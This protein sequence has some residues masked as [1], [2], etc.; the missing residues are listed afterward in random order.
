M[1][2][3]KSLKVD[4][5]RRSYAR[6]TNPETGESVTYD[7][8][9]RPDFSYL[10]WKENRPENFLYGMWFEKKVGI[11]RLT[12][13]DYTFRFESVGSHP[14]ARAEDSGRPGQNCRLDGISLRKFPWEDLYGQ[15]QRYLAEEKKRFAAMVVQ[16][17]KAVANL[18]AAIERFHRDTNEYPRSLDELIDCPERLSTRAGKW[19]YVTEIPADPWEQGYRYTCPGNFNPSGFDVYSVHGNSREPSVWIG[20]WPSPYRIRDA[21]EGEDL[22]VSTKS[23]NVTVSKQAIGVASF[24]PLSLVL[25]PA[26]IL[27]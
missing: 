21:L 14:L 6:V 17:E 25:C 2:F 7:F 23:D 20:N 24:P 9:Y 12:A 19:R 18:D 11:H 5:E 26:V 8:K 22:A 4:I 3:R 16:A 13:G 10:A 15:M 1:T 27:G